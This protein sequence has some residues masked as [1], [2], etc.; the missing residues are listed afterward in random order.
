[1]LH[2]FV[3]V[4]IIDFCTTGFFCLNL[5]SLWVTILIGLIFFVIF[6]FHIQFGLICDLC[7]ELFPK[8]GMSIFS[9]WSHRLRWRI[10]ISNG[11]PKI[12]AALYCFSEATGPLQIKILVYPISLYF[13]RICSHWTNGNVIHPFLDIHS[14]HRPSA[15]ENCSIYHLQIL[16]WQTECILIRILTV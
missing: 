13:I 10:L 12:F 3:S 16:S 6:T 2:N 9:R 7:R 1:M 5:L 8:E 15:N 4:G 14:L 11:S